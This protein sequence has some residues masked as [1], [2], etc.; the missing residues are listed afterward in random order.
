[1]KFLLLFIFIQFLSAEETKYP[2]IKAFIDSEQYYK[3]EL[4][5]QKISN[6][7]STD[8]NLSYYQTEI[9]FQ[10]AEK[11]YFKEN[12]SEAL[13]FYERASKFWVGN[14]LLEDRI[15]E[16]K[17][18]IKYGSRKN[19]SLDSKDSIVSSLDS[20][21][22]IQVIILDPETQEK[23]KSQ[24]IPTNQNTENIV[25]PKYY[26]MYFLGILLSLVLA[27]FL[28]LFIY[29]KERDNGLLQEALIYLTKEKK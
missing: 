2:H 15:K 18:K 20:S 28:I 23:I 17:N 21:K 16:T 14:I 12:F 10:K 4:E 24:I 3:A 29:F 26:F 6:D 19:I 13:I 1:M 27:N 8:P 25:I 5:I 7:F 9:W 11:E 22:T